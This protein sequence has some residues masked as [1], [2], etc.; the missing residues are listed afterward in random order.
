MTANADINNVKVPL[1]LCKVFLLQQ[2][3]NLADPQSR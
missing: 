2:N 3:A 1:S